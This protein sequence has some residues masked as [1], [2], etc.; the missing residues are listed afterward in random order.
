MMSRGRRGFTLME[1]LVVIAI[2]TMLAGMLMGGVMV[3][4]KHAAKRRC[5]V[6]LARIALSCENYSLDFG[7][8]P[9][10]NGDEKSGA[11]LYLALNTEKM[12]GPYLPGLSTRELADVDFDGVMEILDP[13]E[14]PV[15]YLHHSMY[16]GEPGRGKFRII[17]DGPDGVPDTRD[18]ITN[19]D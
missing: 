15:R 17:S 16:E 9:P 10:G 5:S 6:L 3:A 1:M 13:W 4:Q 12:T 11:M 14:R 2:I 8:Y 7:D 18:D 19:W